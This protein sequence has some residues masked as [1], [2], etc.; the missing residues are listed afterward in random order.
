[1]HRKLKFLASVAVV[2]DRSI[3]LVNHSHWYPNLV[4]SDYQHF[5]SKT[6]TLA[7]KLYGNE[8]YDISSSGDFFDQQ[9]YNFPKWMKH[10]P[11]TA[12]LMQESRIARGDYVE[13]KG[14]Y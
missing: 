2:C 1:M 11:N 9:A 13:K 5:P 10:L 6:K 14:L 4:S 12:N 7:G 3:E 8:D